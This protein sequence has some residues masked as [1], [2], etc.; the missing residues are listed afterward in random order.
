MRAAAVRQFGENFFAN[1]NAGLLP[2]MP[3]R[4]AAGGLVGD[5]QP[6]VSQGT[7]IHLHIGG[8]TIGPLQASQDVA[9]Q[10]RQA[11]LMFGAM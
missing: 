7:P 8:Q 5:A 9:A 10:L 4:F 11:A 2:P 1:L 6:A 3:A